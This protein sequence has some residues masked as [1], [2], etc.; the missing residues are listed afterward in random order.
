MEVGETRDELT[1]ASKD[2]LI[3]LEEKLNI[4]LNELDTAIGLMT[5][6]ATPSSARG[7]AGSSP[8]CFLWT[9]TWGKSISS[10]AISCS[11]GE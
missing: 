1:Y 4:N 11:S 3:L 5:G 7:W 6:Y 2:N 8:T 9:L 10:T